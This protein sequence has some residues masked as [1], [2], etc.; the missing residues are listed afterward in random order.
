MYWNVYAEGGKDVQGTDVWAVREG[1]VAI[2]PL[3]V[4]EYDAQAAA[5]L[6]SLTAP[7]RQ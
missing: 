5:T 4:S 1:Y 2:T 6:T 7:A 3:R